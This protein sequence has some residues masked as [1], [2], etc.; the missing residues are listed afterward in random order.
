MKDIILTKEDILIVTEILNV[1]KGL[2]QLSRT[3]LIKNIFLLNELAKDIANLNK[4]YK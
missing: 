2:S 1:E 3:R 4:R